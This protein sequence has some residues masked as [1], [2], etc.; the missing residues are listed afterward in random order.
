M[1]T[2]TVTSRPDSPSLLDKLDEMVPAPLAQFDAFPKLPSTYKAR[3]ESR[4][5]LTLFVAFIAFLLVLNDLGEFI[6]GWPDYEFSVDSDRGNDMDINVDMV[7]NMPCQCECLNLVHMSQ[8]KGFRIGA[9]ERVAI[10]QA[11]ILRLGPFQHHG[12]HSL[13]TLEGIRSEF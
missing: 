12:F 8:S 2:A 6:W 5:F 13:A 1:A 9:G 7:V 11:Q 10:L 3:S 4:G